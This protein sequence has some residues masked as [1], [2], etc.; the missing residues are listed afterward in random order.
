MKR[1]NILSIIFLLILLFTGCKKSEEPVTNLNNNPDEPEIKLLEP[2]NNYSSS[3]YTPLLKW[4]NYT[5]ALN[6]NIILSMDANFISG[7]LLDS[8]LISREINIPDGILT[9]NT[10]YYW[11]VRA[12][13]GNN[14]FS[15][16]SEIR[17]FRV[18]LTAP[19]PPELLLPANNS[20]NQPFLPLFDWSESPT[21]QVYRLQV[22]LN[23][24]FTQIV[25]DTGNIPQ[26]QLEAPYFIINTGTDYYWRVNATNSNG[27][28]TGDW[29]AVYNFRTIDGPKPSSISGRITFT[30]NNFILPPFRYYVSA[31]KTSNW[32]PNSYDPDYKD[33]LS[34]QF[35]NN[36]YIADYR[37]EKII[38]GNYHLT[39]YCDIININNELQHKSVYGCDTARVVFSTCPV[40]SPGTVSIVN[41]NG[42][43]NINMLS[44][45][46][47]SKTIF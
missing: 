40:S 17:R 45:A 31:Y 27:A 4:D 35:I 43:T 20:I 23:S 9:T 6:Y 19:P 18:I 11:K 38:N 7:N 1:N 36:Q 39:V 37:I 41:G 46:D 2:A 22:S 21:A 34:I 44:W 5:G 8:T 15:E 24:A 42:I 12:A 13:T 30:D 47:S 25:L 10:Y 14:N 28:S 29:S 3:N 26:T 16:W 32:P 33:T